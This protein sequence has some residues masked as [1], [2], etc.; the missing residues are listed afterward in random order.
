MNMIRSGV[1]TWTVKSESLAKRVR[2]LADLGF[3]VM[4]FCSGQQ[5]ALIKEWAEV[6][7]VLRERDLRSGR[8]HV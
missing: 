3:K 4:S 5:A 2:A 7:A 1:A 6:A 8:A